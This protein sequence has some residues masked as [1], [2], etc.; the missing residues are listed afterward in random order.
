MRH[1]HHEVVDARMLAWTPLLLRQHLKV[2][3]GARN[4]QRG[5]GDA[6]L[7]RE[8]LERFDVGIARV[9]PKIGIRDIADAFDADAAAR[10]IPQQCER[11]HALGCKVQGACQ[12][13]VRQCRG[14]GELRPFDRLL[15]QALRD[16]ML[17]Y[18][19]QVLHCHERDVVGS[20]LLA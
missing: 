15:G 17:L 2:D 18:E 7:V 1:L 20:D 3:G 4:F 10:P 11:R 14:A 8:I 6:V 16:E 19:L 13:R 12:H 5:N 9:E